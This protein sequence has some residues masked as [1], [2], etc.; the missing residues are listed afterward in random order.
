[1]DFHLTIWLPLALIVDSSARMTEISGCWVET[2][3][4][5]F[6]L[7]LNVYFQKVDDG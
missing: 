4:R 6:T 1:M 2:P 7:Y 5:Y 3:V